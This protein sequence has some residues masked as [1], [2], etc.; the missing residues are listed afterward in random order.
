MEFSKVRVV[1]RPDHLGVLPEDGLVM[2]RMK[3]AGWSEDPGTGKAVMVDDERGNPAYEVLNPIPMAPPIGWVPTPPIEE[4]IRQRVA[5]EFMLRE[6]EEI[7]DINDAEDFDIPDELPPLETIYEVMGMEPQAP[8][9]KEPTP[10]ER[11]AAQV[12]YEEVLDRHRRVVARRA[13]EEYE[14][15]VKEARDL[16]GEPPDDPNFVRKDEGA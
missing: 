8:A 1:V 14:R 2:E 9:V 4:L 15:K 7:D 5:Q 11:A 6:D 3:D 10:E 16:H 12:A 13:R